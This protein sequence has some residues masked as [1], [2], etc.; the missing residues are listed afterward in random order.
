MKLILL[1][2][3][4]TTWLDSYQ[5]APEGGA[6]QWGYT[7]GYTNGIYRAIQPDHKESANCL[8]FRMLYQIDKDGSK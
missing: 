6:A 5:H 2:L 8:K 3:I 4:V 1:F 7:C